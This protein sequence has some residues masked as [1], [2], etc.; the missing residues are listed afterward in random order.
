[1]VVQDSN[2]E[3][4]DLNL[5]LNVGVLL[6]PDIVLVIDDTGKASTQS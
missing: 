2:K 5:Y 1:M 3:P 4:S 6:E